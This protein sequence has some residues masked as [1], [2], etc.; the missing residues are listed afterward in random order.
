[1]RTLRER[2]AAGDIDRRPDP[3]RRNAFIYALP[4]V[5]PDHAD[6]R[7]VS[8]SD[9]PNSPYF[10]KLNYDVP[11]LE[12]GEFKTVNAGN[13]NEVDVDRLRFE[14]RKKARMRLILSDVHVPIHNEPTWWAMLRFAH[15]LKPDAGLLL[16]DFLDL[17]SFS[18]HGH[19]SKPPSAHMELAAGRS[20]LRHL[21]AANPETDWW[22][23]EG[24]HEQRLRR[25]LA[26]A[27]PEMAELISLPQLLDL[28]TLGF[29]WH[30]YPD[31]KYFGNVSYKHATSEAM[32]HAHN[33]LIRED[34]CTVY[35]HTHRPQLHMKRT[36]SGRFLFAM[37]LGCGEDLNGIDGPE[38][39][40]GASPGW[41]NAIG[42]VAE[43]EDG[44]A[45]PFLIPIIDGVLV[46]D[47]IVI[48]GNQQKAG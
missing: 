17:T 2:G 43:R 13:E 34:A 44:T 46:W 35:G 3:Q 8:P 39:L 31:K 10:D 41:V 24:N 16:G 38:W 48:D 21:R 36:G 27:S 25:H 18:S 15:H 20:A 28:K 23:F 4:M 6:V 32:H 11:Q 45:Y 9:R 22:Y 47:N 26:K 7:P 42:V 40:N 19:L 29:K 12:E 14:V 1:M 5:G 37:G 30:P 33:T